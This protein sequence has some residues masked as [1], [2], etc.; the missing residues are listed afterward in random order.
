MQFLG[1][2]PFP[3]PQNIGE[4][5]VQYRKMQGLS[6]EEFARCLKVDPATLGRWERRERRPEGK[7]LAKVKAVLKDKL[8]KP[9]PWY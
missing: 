4:Q 9:A 1:Y 2:N 7:F 6:Q 3:V 5:L 8:L